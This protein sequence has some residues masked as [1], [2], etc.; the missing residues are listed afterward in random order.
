MALD[1]DYKGIVTALRSSHESALTIASPCSVNEV[2]LGVLNG[3]LSSNH[4]EIQPGLV[5]GFQLDMK[6]LEVLSLFHIQAASIWGPANMAGTF[7]TEGLRLMTCVGAV[8]LH[9]IVQADM[10]SEPSFTA[11]HPDLHG[12]V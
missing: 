9:A 8:L 6:D 1:C 12:H 5:Y 3:T 4:G 11:Y 2:M 7:R 10:S